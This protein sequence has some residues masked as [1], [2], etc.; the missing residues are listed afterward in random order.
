MYLSGSAGLAA[1]WWLFAPLVVWDKSSVDISVP[2]RLT[3]SM[4]DR[5]AND[6]SERPQSQK[7]LLVQLSLSTRL[8]RQQSQDL[9]SFV[10]LDL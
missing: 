5:T 2:L 9:L 7:L 3:T 10:L 4:P 1:I 8:E 6:K